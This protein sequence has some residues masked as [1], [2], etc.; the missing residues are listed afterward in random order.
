MSGETEL[1]EVLDAHR[2]SAAKYDCIVTISGGRDSTYTLWKLAVDY[3][4]RVLA[5]NYQNPF[6]TPEGQNNI[7]NAVA[8]LD[9]DLVQFSLPRRLH[10]RS[11][12]HYLSCWLK[13]PSAAM[14]PMI[15]AA[16]KLMWVEIPRI[17]RKHG[18]SLIV[19][20]GNPLESVS[21][22]HLTLPTN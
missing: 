9:V 7:A 11:L 4:M 10:Q 18:I 12:R 5:V 6:A 21:Y 13:R 2:N 17:A 3:G 1:L 8:S 22:T 16:C 14:V 19:S 20:G 15:C